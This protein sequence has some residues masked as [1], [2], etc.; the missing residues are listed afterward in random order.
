MSITYEDI[1]RQLS[2]INA[3]N[4]SSR[5]TSPRKGTFLHAQRIKSAMKFL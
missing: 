1:E 4:A 3:L 2:W 5:N